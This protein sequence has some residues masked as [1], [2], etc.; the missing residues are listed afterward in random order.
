G[1]APHL[2]QLVG[3]A[4]SHRI[5]RST[6]RERDHQ[7]DRFGR[8]GLRRCLFASGRQ[9]DKKDC[10]RK[11]YG[12]EAVRFIRHDLLQLLLKIRSAIILISLAGSLSVAPPGGPVCPV[13]R[14]SA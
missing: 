3:D 10:K 9:R 7:L 2:R 8:K 13:E 12:E 5:E 11:R 14:Q 6:R 1:L 4:T